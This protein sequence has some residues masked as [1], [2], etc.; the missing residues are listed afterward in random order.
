MEAAEAEVETAEAAA[1]AE[2]AAAEAAAEAAEAAAAAATED[3]PLTGLMEQMAV[4]EQQIVAASATMQALNHRQKKVYDT[5]LLRDEINAR[6]AQ[7]RQREQ[8]SVKQLTNEINARLAE[9]RL[10]AQ[11]RFEERD[12]EEREAT[13]QLKCETRPLRTSPVSSAPELSDQCPSL[14]IDRL[15]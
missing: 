7:Q 6:L 9:R 10:Q 3:G 12:H 11:R 14:R 5:K 4:A 8:E 1:E 2:V 15:L 13:R